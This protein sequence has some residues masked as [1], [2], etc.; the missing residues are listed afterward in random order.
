MQLGSRQY[1][2]RHL[3][4]YEKKTAMVKK[5]LPISTKRSIAF[6]L[7]SLKIEM[8]MTLEVIA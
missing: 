3:S 7:T 4:S 2:L 6:N 1:N 5:T 8:T